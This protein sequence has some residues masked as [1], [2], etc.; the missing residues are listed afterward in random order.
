MNQA[1]NMTDEQL[2]NLVLSYVKADVNNLRDKNPGLCSFLSS[3]TIVSS[4][5][6]DEAMR[7]RI[8]G[9]MR[10]NPPK[11][12]AEK[13]FDKRTN[14]I[15]FYILLDEHWWER[16]DWNSR[17]K[18]LESLLLKAKYAELIGPDKAYGK[19][20]QEYMLILKPYV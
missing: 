16:F 4:I 20:F 19:S 8:K 5:F 17:I 11:H 13:Y 7:I 2:I 6:F 15:L 14:S 12:I 3:L 18:Y 1:N 10:Y 9:I